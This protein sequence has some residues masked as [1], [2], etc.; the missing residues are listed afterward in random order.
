MAIE[1]KNATLRSN[2][3]LGT[4]QVRVGP[5]GPVLVE[6]VVAVAS[7][8]SA[9]SVYT[10]ARIPSNARIH[11]A[12]RLALDDLASA[13]APTLDIGLKAV[14]SNITTDADALTDGIDAATASAGALVVKDHANNGKMAWEYVSGQATDPGGF[15]DVI[16]SLL[17]AD[18][19]VGGDVSLLLFYSVD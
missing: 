15:L 11:G 7:T 19:N 1:T 10:M 3:A 16:V 18:V 6:S 17:D 5:V 12:S 14:N 9:T 4:N 8:A 2:L 13:G